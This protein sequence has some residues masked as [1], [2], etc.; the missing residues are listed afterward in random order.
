LLTRLNVCTQVSD[1][2][3]A[4]ALMMKPQAAVTFGSGWLA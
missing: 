2:L 1:M 3:T 4:D